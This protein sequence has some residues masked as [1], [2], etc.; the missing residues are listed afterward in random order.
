MFH[1]AYR[2]QGP[3]FMDLPPTLQPCAVA[4]AAPSSDHLRAATFAGLIYAALGAVIVA[5]SSLAPRSA[6]APVHP[7][8]PG[9]TFVFEPPSAFRL[10]LAQPS[11]VA[12]PVPGHGGTSEPASPARAA[13]PAQVPS[14]AAA[15]LPTEDHHGDSLRAGTGRVDGVASPEVPF[16]G[17]TVGSAVYDFTTVGLAV[18]HRVDPIYPEF[19]RRAR[20]QGPVVLMMTVDEWGQPIQVQVM[21]G[22][23]VFHETAMQA[24]RQWRFEPARLNGRPVS[25]AFRLTLKFALR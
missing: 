8:D 20:I 17:P 16:T 9:R 6:P 2:G 14:E 23:P 5:G 1:V 11:P 21:E 25:A 15:G 24:A 12:G 4:A 3:V 19:A 18:L 22:H 13:P 7:P 10:T